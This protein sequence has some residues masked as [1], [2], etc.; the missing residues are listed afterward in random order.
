MFSP[1]AINQL[2]MCYYQGLLF[3]LR[4]GKSMNPITK[5][6]TDLVSATSTFSVQINSEENLTLGDF[7]FEVQS[8]VN[9]LKIISLIMVKFPTYHTQTKAQTWHKEH[10]RYRMGEERLDG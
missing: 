2:K 3:A 6:S 10:E 8:Y 9:K 5:K 4:I 7:L 1:L